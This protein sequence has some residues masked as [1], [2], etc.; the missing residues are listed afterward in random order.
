M[1]FSP[2]RLEIEQTIAI[3]ALAAAIELHD[4]GTPGHNARVA[5]LAVSIGRELK[6]DADALRVLAHAGLL[7][8][9]GKLG[10]SDTILYKSLPLT[11][12]ERMDIRRH[13]GLGLEVLD[14]IGG[15]ERE[16]Q[17][18]FSHHE[19]LDGSGYPRGLSAEDIPLET[20]ILAVADTYDAMIADRPYRAGVGTP[21]A[22]ASIL[23]ERNRTLDARCVD[24]LVAV[25]AN[26]SILFLPSLASLP[27]FDFSEGGERRV[28][29]NNRRWQGSLDRRLQTP[30][31]PAP[32]IV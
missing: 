6:L 28:G 12:I 3:A 27:F 2:A 29:D 13:P 15:L 18:I 17:I 9:L 23:A 14:K 25:V 11:E 31:E 22:L 32:V 8:D 1:A 4:V 21:A 16:K 19:R 5:D 7:H 24:A 10:V 30:L 20:R 26:N